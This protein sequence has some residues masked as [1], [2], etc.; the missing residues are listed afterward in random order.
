MKNTETFTVQYQEWKIVWKTSKEPFPGAG[1]LQA[2]LH[3][4]SG[5]LDGLPINQLGIGAGETVMRG[6]GVYYLEVSSAN[7]TWEISV[8]DYRIAE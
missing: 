8:Y 4:S 2:Y 7:M 1:L 5:E 3:T 6:S